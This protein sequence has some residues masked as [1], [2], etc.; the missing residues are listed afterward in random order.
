MLA[1]SLLEALMCPEMPNFSADSTQVD[2]QK[3]SLSIKELS[4]SIL[5]VLQAK[6][7]SDPQ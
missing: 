6:S 4:Y 3:L 2:H 5:A 1:L 7:V